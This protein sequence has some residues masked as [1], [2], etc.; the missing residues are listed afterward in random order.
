MKTQFVADLQNNAMLGHTGEVAL[1]GWLGS[2]R[3]H[4]NLLFLDIMD[5]TGSIQ[6]VVNRQHV[7]EE[8]FAA[9]SSVSEESAVEATGTLQLHPRTGE[10]ELA[11]TDFAVINLATMDFTPSPRSYFDIF[12]PKYTDLILRQRHIYLRN[13]RVMAILRFRSLVMDVARRWFAQEG[14]LEFDAPIL[15]PV[16]LYHDRTAIDLAVHDEPAFLSQCAGFYLEAAA[17]AF[18]KVYNMAPSFRGE[19]SRSKRHLTEYWHIK[20][21]LTWGNREDVIALVENMIAFMNRTLNEEG[22]ELMEII[23]VEPRIDGM[24]VPFERITYENAIR[25]LQGQGFDINFGD[26]LGTNEEEELAKLH[27]GPFWVVGI[28]R[29]V[30]PFPYVIDAE[31]TRLTMVADLIAS[32]G[33]GELLGVAEKIFDPSMLN[34]R[35][36]EKDKAGDPRYNFVKEV[37]EAGC[38]PHI[39]FGMGLERAIRW[40][41][42]I[43]HV[44]DTIAFPRVAGRRFYP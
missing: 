13:P 21:E 30:E 10:V 19:E 38:A 5:S 31:D 22:A 41:L 37:H 23:G 42:S 44:R 25:H 24:N 27:S 9:C 17:Q 35:M 11:V 29:V 4:G 20:A 2:K 14:F 8:A 28:P 40:F 1:S 15:V 3:D 12:D 18:E 39:A 32:D 16:P 34:E 7:S 43:P 26:G 36:L 33:Y 6:A